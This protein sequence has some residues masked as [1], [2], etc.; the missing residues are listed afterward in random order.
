MAT[1]VFED[2]LHKSWPLRLL[3]VW[4]GP[5]VWVEFGWFGMPLKV[6]GWGWAKGLGGV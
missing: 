1:F 2:P 6:G 3:G 5:Q 4:V